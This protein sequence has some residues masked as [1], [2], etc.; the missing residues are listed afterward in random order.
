[1]IAGDLLLIVL[2]GGGG[3]DCYWLVVVVWMAIGCI[4]YWCI[5][6]GWF[7]ELLVS[8]LIDSDDIIL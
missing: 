5:H 2:L 4:H 1:M 7:C 8:V 6:D 3:M